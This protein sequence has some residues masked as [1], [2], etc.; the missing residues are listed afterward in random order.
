MELYQP[1]SSPEALKALKAFG[2][3]VL[4]SAPKAIVY[5]G[6]R[7]KN[8]CQTLKGNGKLQWVWCGNSF[9]FVCEYRVP[10]INT[11]CDAYSTEPYW[12]PNDIDTSSIANPTICKYN[13]V[14]DE[15]TIITVTDEVAKE[16]IYSFDCAN[17]EAYFLPVDLVNSFPNLR[18]IFCEGYNIKVL[19][20]RSLHG[21][22]KL[23]YL[24]LDFNYIE[25]LDANVFKDLTSLKRLDISKTKFKTFD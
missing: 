10:V 3:S 4:K 5:I 18:A 12:N 25:V 9:N 6:G 19:T 14:I 23:V 13:G 21:L 15:N 2:K 1:N 8:L 7:N 11:K 16:D 17:S 24:G 22:T 20:G